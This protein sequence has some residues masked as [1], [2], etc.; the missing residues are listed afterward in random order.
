MRRALARL[1]ACVVLALVAVCGSAAISMRPADRAFTPPDYE[2]VYRAWTREGDQFAF[3]KL[4]DVLNVTATFQSWEFRRAY[5]VRYAE[6]F[7]LVNDERDTMLASSLE[8]ARHQHRFFV[9]LAGHNFRESDLTSERS[10]WRVLLVTA[11]GRHVAPSAIERV[12]RPTPAEKRY[13]PSISPFRQTFRISFDVQDATGKATVGE[14]AAYVVLRFTGVQGTEDL[15]WSF[16]PPGGA[17][18]RR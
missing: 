3:G 4:A 12:K 6:D 5:V 16:E 8:D 14:D 13:F 1:G 7:S 18:R 17:P 9:T 10:A 2:S 11:D 15:R